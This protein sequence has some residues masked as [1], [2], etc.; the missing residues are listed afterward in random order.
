M[1]HNL[2]VLLF[3]V[4]VWLESMFLAFGNDKAVLAKSKCYVDLSPSTST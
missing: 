2:E 3:T 4:K 1:Y